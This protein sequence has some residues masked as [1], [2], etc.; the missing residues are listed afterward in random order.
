VSR[1]RLSV[2]RMGH[3]IV[4]SSANGSISSCS[5]CQ[6]CSVILADDVFSANLMLISLGR[7]ML[8]WVWI[9]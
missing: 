4:V 2:Q 1:A 8:S 6:G 3:P 9:G 5:V 7:L